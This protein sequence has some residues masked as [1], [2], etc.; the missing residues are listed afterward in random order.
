MTE[1]KMYERRPMSYERDRVWAEHYKVDS[2]DGYAVQPLYG[3]P[4]DIYF[5]PKAEFEREYREVS[6]QKGQIIPGHPHYEKVKTISD[7]EFFSGE[8]WDMNGRP[9]FDD[10]PFAFTRSRMGE[11]PKSSLAKVFY[12]E[13]PDDRIQIVGFENFLS[14][15]EIAIKYGPDIELKYKTGTPWMYRIDS[16]G[17]ELKL[18]EYRIEI[19]SPDYEA[20]HRVY[21][22]KY[23]KVSFNEII[24]LMK[25][26]GAHLSKIVKKSREKKS[27]VKVVEI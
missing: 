22:T 23:T 18:Y 20:C 27:D 9:L 16:K 3:G 1:R 14:L 5:V 26:C 19:I 21:K 2:A 7:Q 4:D 8:K 11:K 25:Q 24:D 10:S 6:L 12:R 15:E 13:L 17:E